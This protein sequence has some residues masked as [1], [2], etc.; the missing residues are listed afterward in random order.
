MLNLNVELNKKIS[1]CR[2]GPK[3]T[4]ENKKS[5]EKIVKNAKQLYETRNDISNAIEMV[6]FPPDKD[7][8]K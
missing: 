2:K 7:R 3:H 4:A 1:P 5:M 6:I 8:K